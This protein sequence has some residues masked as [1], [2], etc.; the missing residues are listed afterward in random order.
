[1]AHWGK[2]PISIHPEGWILFI[3]L[4]QCLLTFPL[5]QMLVCYKVNIPT[6]VL[7]E[8]GLHVNL[9]SEELPAGLVPILS[10]E[11]TVSYSIPYLSYS[12]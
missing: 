11:N 2:C 8:W 1:M 7:A 3:G 12:L 6:V 10:A 4:A 5:L 9:F